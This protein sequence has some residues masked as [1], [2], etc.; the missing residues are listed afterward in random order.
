M[1]DLYDFNRKFGVVFCETEEKHK[2][3]QFIN[4]DRFFLI[5]YGKKH[6]NLFKKYVVCNGTFKFM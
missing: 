6:R 4:S 5:F 2:F 1:N 3:F